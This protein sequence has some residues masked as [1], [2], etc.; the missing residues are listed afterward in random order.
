MPVNRL[1]LLA[2]VFGAAI[3][4]LTGTIFAA[5]QL[6]VFPGNFD[7]PLLITLYAMVILGG[8]GSLPGVVIGAIA[9]N[10]SLELLRDAGGRAAGSSSLAIAL[11][12]LALV[13]PLGAA[14]GDR[15]RDD[16]LRLRRL[17]DR[18]RRLRRAWV[19]RLDRGRPAR[20]ASLDG[21]VHPS[22][23]PTRLGNIGFV[24]AHRGRARADASCAGCWRTCCSCPTLYLAAFVWENLLVAEP[25][26]TRILLLGALLVVLMTWRPQGLFGTAG[27]DR[28]SAGCS[29]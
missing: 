26:V 13:R 14:R 29:S 28:V 17:P 3:A 20:P 10:V 11:G 7:V 9:I 4:G 23:D 27:G 6:G 18:R 24:A 2:F 5:V 1:K 25:S 21:W 16:R 12:L 8:V 19:V 22:R 15:R